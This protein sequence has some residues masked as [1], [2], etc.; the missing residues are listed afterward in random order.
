[1]ASGLQ[2]GT[3]TVTVT[4]ANNC[5]AAQSFTI[6]EPPILSASKS[7]TDVLCNGGATGTASVTVSGGSGNYTYSWSPSGG[8]AAVATGLTAGT[9]TVTVADAN[10]CQLTES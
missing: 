5:Q 1:T 2:A 7:Q 10:S 8:T 3:Y 6:A 4:D 9:Y